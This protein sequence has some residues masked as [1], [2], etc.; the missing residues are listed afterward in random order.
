MVEH[1][2]ECVADTLCGVERHW[3][4]EF[5]LRA[6]LDYSDRRDA[7]RWSVL[8]LEA[9]RARSRLVGGGRAAGPGVDQQHG[10][11]GRQTDSANRVIHLLEPQQLLDHAD[12]QWQEQL[13]ESLG[14]DRSSR[15]TLESNQQLAGRFLLLERQ[16]GCR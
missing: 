1:P 4:A 11:E 16:V 10:R 15:S 8:R 14:V 13:D 2:H 9:R 6:P 3:I 7:R 5:D 12:D